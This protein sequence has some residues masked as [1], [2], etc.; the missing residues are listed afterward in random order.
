MLFLQCILKYM[1][2][3]IGIFTMCACLAIGN[4]LQAQSKQQHKQA[5]VIVI[6]A[7]QNAE[8]KTVVEIINGEIFIDGK[9]VDAS[10][11]NGHVKI[12][13][14]KKEQIIDDGSFDNENTT[15]QNGAFA[16]Q[17]KAMLG[18][19]TNEYK[20]NQGAQIEN[21]TEGSP[22]DLSGLK[23][24]DIITKVNSTVINNPQDLVTA[25]NSYNP[26]DKIDL[27]ILRNNDE[28]QIAVILAERP[29]MA[30]NRMGG[31]MQ[32]MP[33]SMDDFF[34]NFGS[35]MNDLGTSFGNMRI[36]QNGREITNNEQGPKIGA[37]VEDRADNDGVRVIDIKEN[38]VADKAG[39]KVND[40]ITTVAG[41]NIN[42]IDDLSRALLQA[43]NK[44]DIVLN[45]KRGTKAET[46]YLEMPVQLRKKDF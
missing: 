9:K 36:W 14:K 17:G 27:S 18:V 34:K 25:I 23:A 19:R 24:G 32:P 43:K 6:E 30:N 35:D 10:A 41:A 3:T 20:T 11:K 13:K 5:D 39:L 40:V 26:Q 33:F 28:K 22:A 1:K 44:K 45:I 31:G 2:K 46:I 37:E 29:S 15:D 42:N 38:S 7:E 16:N 12:I 4:N 21:V 8:E